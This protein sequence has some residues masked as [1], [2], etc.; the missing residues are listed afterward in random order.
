MIDED[1][2]VN[3]LSFLDRKFH[4]SRPVRQGQWLRKRQYIILGCFTNKGVHDGVEA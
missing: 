1:G 4:G 2:R 3:Y